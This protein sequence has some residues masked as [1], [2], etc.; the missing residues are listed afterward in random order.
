MDPAPRTDLD[1]T[2]HAIRAARPELGAAFRD[3]LLFE[4]GRA[5]VS[6]P[7]PAS[8]PL[9]WAC[10]ALVLALGLGVVTGRQW[11]ARNFDSQHLAQPAPE[12]ETDHVPSSPLLVLDPPPRPDGMIV[13]GDRRLDGLL[14]NSTLSLAGGPATTSEIL[15][16]RAAVHA[17]KSL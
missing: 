13:A 1:L 17:W 11:S 14:Q 15:T 12:P 4:A 9:R 3:Q 6:R 16:P 5:A 10:A 8:I 7:R 2:L